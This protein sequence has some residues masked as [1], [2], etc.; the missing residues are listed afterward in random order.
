MDP[1]SQEYLNKI[2]AKDPE[3][4]NHNEI[5]FLRARVSYLKAAQVEEYDSVLNPKVKV[6]TS[7]KE[8]VKKN[9]N[10]KQA[11]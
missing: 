2:L 3:T 1:K 11:N 7:Q 9:A 4:L 5:V 8:T 6:Q 10:T